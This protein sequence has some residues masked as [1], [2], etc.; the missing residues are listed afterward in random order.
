MHIGLFLI[1]Y[2]CTNK[3]KRFRCISDAHTVMYVVAFMY[4]LLNLHSQTAFPAFV[5][6]AFETF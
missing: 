2:K 1:L 5:C 6:E 4:K 3:L